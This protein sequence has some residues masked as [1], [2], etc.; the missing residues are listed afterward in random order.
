MALSEARKRANAKWDAAN[1]K[2]ISCKARADLV[3]TFKALCRENGETPNAVLTG[4]M[5]A[6]I[7][8]YDPD[9]ED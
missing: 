5:E 9:P 3:E 4:A 2:V 1:T 7:A 8:K 6:Y